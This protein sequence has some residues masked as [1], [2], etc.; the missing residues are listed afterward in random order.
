[1]S[2]AIHS[3]RL[4]LAMTAVIVPTVAAT[5]AGCVRRSPRPATH[6]V[7][8]ALSASGA[9]VRG[10]VIYAGPTLIARS[11]AEGR[12]PLDVNGDEG[13]AFD[14]RV[15]CPGGYQSPAEPLT[16]RNLRIATPGNAAPEYTVTCHETRHALVVVVRADGG[17]DLPV[18]YLGKEV[19]RTDGSGAAHVSFD[20]DV[21][22]RIELV[23]GTSGSE[24]EAM[25]PQNPA[26]V[27]EMPDHDD[28]QV[29]SVTFTR[30]RK[31]P[32][33]RWAPRGPVRL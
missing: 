4:A 29:F 17:P 20:M 25:H 24:N 12:A 30:D 6:V 11:D 2:F 19:A 21:H 32:P 31:A 16:L 3:C 26:S 13:E 15:Q 1:M 28:V 10:A 22:D 14:V 33:P 8:R 5:L 7:V 18:L 27:F 9:P 23:L